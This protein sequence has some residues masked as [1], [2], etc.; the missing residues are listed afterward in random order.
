VC[1]ANGQMHR[2]SRRARFSCHSRNDQVA[3]RAGRG[4]CVARAS[5]PCRFTCGVKGKGACTFWNS[6]AALGVQSVHE[7]GQGAAGEWPTSGVGGSH[8]LG[9]DDGG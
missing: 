9:V 8:P 1:C 4:W 6:D 3:E 2:F 5:M 7:R